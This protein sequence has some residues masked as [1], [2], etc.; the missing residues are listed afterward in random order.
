MHLQPGGIF[1]FVLP[2][3]EHLVHDYLESE[4]AAAAE[5]FMRDARLGREVRPKGLI[6]WLREWIGNS[7]HLWMWDFK[8][9]AS[10]LDS[11]GFVG[12]RRAQFGDSADPRFKEVEDVGRWDSCL[13]VECHRPSV[14]SLD[15]ASTTSSRG[16][17]L[18]ETSPHS[19]RSRPGSQS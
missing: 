17:A 16:I 15:M 4:D 11:A 18:P 8:S 10:E 6:A 9:I 12:I 7:A 2:D 5:R 13:G 3:L 19:T 1:R 14:Q